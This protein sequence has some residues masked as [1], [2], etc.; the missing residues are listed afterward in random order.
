MEGTFVTP[1]TVKILSRTN[2]AEENTTNCCYNSNHHG[3]VSC[4]SSTTL[5]VYIC[6]ATTDGHYAWSIQ[7]YS[8]WTTRQ[9][10]EEEE[11]LENIVSLLSC[12]SSMWFNIYSSIIASWSLLIS[13]LFITDMLLLFQD[14]TMSPC[15]YHPHFTNHKPLVCLFLSELPTNNISP[16]PPHLWS[17]IVSIPSRP[18]YNNNKT[19]PTRMALGAWPGC[20]HWIDM[21]ADVIII[22]SLPHIRA[23]YGWN[24]CT[25]KRRPYR[26]AIIILLFWMPSFVPRT[27]LHI[28]PHSPTMICP[29][30]CPG[31]AHTGWIIISRVYYCYYPMLTI[32]SYTVMSPLNCGYTHCCTSAWLID[33]FNNYYV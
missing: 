27:Y 30:R 20:C 28:L 11:L 33:T 17:L 22:N 18:W 1:T 5:V 23:C 26:T 3:H 24:V 7:D 10:L 6:D 15:H 4:T 25:Y 16:L 31:M 9:Q 8:S 32:V 21:L 12:S 13:L 14:M 19:Y 29:S 2:E